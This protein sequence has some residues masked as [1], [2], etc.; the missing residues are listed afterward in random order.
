MEKEEEKTH[1][2]I[3]VRGVWNIWSVVHVWAEKR[4]YRLVY[5]HIYTCPEEI[6]GH[7]NHERHKKIK[8]QV[9]WYKVYMQHSLIFIFF[10]TLP[11]QFGISIIHNLYI[12]Y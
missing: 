8:Q 2:M 12:A 11:L 1:N 7:K 6:F 10:L 3:D 9:T 5:V 4:L